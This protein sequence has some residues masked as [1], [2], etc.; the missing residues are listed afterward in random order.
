MAARRGELILGGCELPWVAEPVVECS[1]CG[2]QA[3]FRRSRITP[4]GE[5]R[6]IAATDLGDDWIVHRR[7]DP[8]RIN[9]MG[10]LR[11]LADRCVG[12][13]LDGDLRI[14]PTKAPFSSGISLSYS[15]GWFDQYQFEHDLYYPFTNDQ[16]WGVVS[17]MGDLVRFETNVSGIADDIPRVEGIEVQIH[18]LNARL[19]S[20][21]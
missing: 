10:N 1:V 11:D 8:L 18:V 20:T 9:D 7:A 17:D 5:A 16:F 14:V 15:C 13:C 6:R 3:T 21:T 12:A 2:R 4:I 19:P